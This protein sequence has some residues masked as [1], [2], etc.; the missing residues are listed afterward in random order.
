MGTPGSASECSMQS[1]T[2][3]ACPP[4]SFCVIHQ[5]T[6]Y[7]EWMRNVN[8]RFTPSEGGSIQIN[9]S[10]LVNIHQGNASSDHTNPVHPSVYTE[11]LRQVLEE[12][13]IR[14]DMTTAA[15][16]QSLYGQSQGDDGSSW[17]ITRDLAN[18]PSSAEAVSGF[19]ERGLNRQRGMV[20][21]QP[22]TFH[23]ASQSHQYS[24]HLV[25][26]RMAATS[27]MGRDAEMFTQRYRHHDLQ[28]VES[29]GFS[30]CTAQSQYYDFD[31]RMAENHFSP[32]GVL[33]RSWTQTG[34]GQ[35]TRL[36]VQQQPGQGDRQFG[37]QEQQARSDVSSG[38]CPNPKRQWHR[39]AFQQFQIPPKRSW[40]RPVET[41]AQTASANAESSSSATGGDY[42]EACYSGDL[43]TNTTSTD[44]EGQPGCGSVT[45]HSEHQP[46]VASAQTQQSED[47]D[48]IFIE[49]SEF[50][51]IPLQVTS[52]KVEKERLGVTHPCCEI[53]AGMQNIQGQQLNCVP[54]TK[55]IAPSTSAG[56][57][58]EQQRTS[59]VSGLQS[60]ADNIG[61]QQHSQ[62]QNPNLTTSAAPASATENSSSLEQSGNGNPDSVSLPA[63]TAALSGSVSSLAT[64]NPQGRHSDRT[65]YQAFTTPALHVKSE[66]KDEDEVIFVKSEPR[67]DQSMDSFSLPSVL[68]TVSLH[69][70][71]STQPE[72]ST[73]ITRKSFQK[74]S[75]E[76]FF[77][78]GNSDG[79]CCYLTQLPTQFDVH[80]R[81]VHAQERCYPC[82]HCGSLEPSSDALLHHLEQ[83]LSLQCLLLY[84]VEPSCAYNSYSAEDV[85]QHI[86]GCHSSLDTFT[87]WR[88]SVSF[89]SLK[90]FVDHVKEN[91]L[92]IVRCPHCSAKDT[93]HWR[94]LNH[95]SVSHPGSGRMI[96]VHKMFLCQERALTGWHAENKEQSATTSTQGMPECLHASNNILTDKSIN[97]PPVLPAD[98]SV[99]HNPRPKSD[100]SHIDLTVSSCPRQDQHASEDE[101][102]LDFEHEDNSEDQRC[103]Q[104]NTQ[105]ARVAVNWMTEK[106]DLSDSE[107]VASSSSADGEMSDSQSGQPCPQETTELG[108]EKVKTSCETAAPT[109]SVST[110]S[111]TSSAYQTRG[112]HV[113]KAVEA[114]YSRDQ[115]TT[116]TQ[117]Q[118][119]CGLT[120]KE[121]AD[122]AGCKIIDTND[123]RTGQDTLELGA[124][125]EEGTEID[126]VESPCEG[127]D[128]DWCFSPGN[129]SLAKNLQLQNKEL[130]SWFQKSYVKPSDNDGA[131]S[132]ALQIQCSYCSHGSCTEEHHLCHLSSHHVEYFQGFSCMCGY[133]SFHMDDSVD[134][135]CLSRQRRSAAKAQFGSLNESLLSSLSM[136]R[137]Q[138]DPQVNNDVR[139]S[140]EICS[141]QAKHFKR[142]LQDDCQAAEP[143]RKKQKLQPLKHALHKSSEVKAKRRRR[144]SSKKTRLHCK[145]CAF[146]AYSS[147]S[148]YAHMYVHHREVMQCPVCA[149]IPKN[150]RELYG[151]LSAA[152]PQMKNSLS[153]QLKVSNWITTVKTQAGSN[154]KEN[155]A[156]NMLEDNAAANRRRAHAKAKKHGD[157]AVTKRGGAAA[158]KRRVDA[159]VKKPVVKAAA[160]NFKKRRDTAAE[161][162]VKDAA[163]MKLGISAVAEIHGNA[164]V[165]KQGK[166][167]SAIKTD[168]EV[169]RYPGGASEI[170]EADATPESF[171]KIPAS[172]VIEL[173]ASSLDVETGIPS[174]CFS[175]DPSP[176]ETTTGESTEFEYRCPHCIN[177]LKT[178]EKFYAHLCYH[179]HY[180]CWKCAHCG[181]RAFG[182]STV[183]NHINKKHPDQMAS[184]EILH[185]LHISKENRCQR[186]IERCCV[187]VSEPYSEKRLQAMEK[188]KLKKQLKKEGRNSWKSKVSSKNTSR[189]KIVQ[190][191]RMRAVKPSSSTATADKWLMCPYCRSERK[192]L[193]AIE[194]EIRFHIHYK[195]FSCP[196]CT[197][198]PFE[199]SSQTHIEKHILNDHPG[200]RAKVKVTRIPEKEARFKVLLQR[201]I[202]LSKETV[203]SCKDVKRRYSLNKTAPHTVSP[204]KKPKASFS[205]NSGSTPKQ[206]LSAESSSSATSHSHQT[207]MSADSSEGS[208]SH[209]SQNLSWAQDCFN[210]T[211]AGV[212]AVHSCKLCQ[213]SFVRGN[214]TR[215]LYY[216]RMWKHWYDRHKKSAS[217]KPKRQ[218]EELVVK[219]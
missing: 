135:R 130:P 48:I 207:C 40:H 204:I 50:K 208:T 158:K 127:R 102:I 134:H 4:S 34:Q 186:V 190:K 68:E 1:C 212:E 122:I 92:Q 197:V 159:K 97:Q 184:P 75:A 145:L 136:Y 49:K 25:P 177:I 161:K 8:P 53:P 111:S 71:P 178:R 119:G 26:P 52:V 174:G 175:S 116:G 73:S 167:V 66:P 76:G 24:S 5:D 67:E 27:V 39:P 46:D 80:L 128:M 43:P 138:S 211:G 132:N 32:P 182:K 23:S 203:T 195:P 108:T 126:R 13:S 18:P 74:L 19:V 7:A 41:A 166:D 16:S 206:H 162:Q 58:V 105:D 106:L 140:Q 89:L 139:I 29:H 156:E 191:S 14:R 171:E 216:N 160:K 30:P 17:H 77:R 187:P 98:D 93:D 87:C 152:H 15:Q 64:E 101:M 6:T 199:S 82:V 189:S 84:C 94:I 124:E 180:R 169:M 141:K 154:H 69:S 28:C 104:S 155:S 21:V 142:R 33:P 54:S 107:E 86:A 163:A 83:H 170:S 209:Q 57:S 149:L 198:S 37:H 78:C 96:S 168:V 118:L 144:I 205:V 61:R 35:P 47:Y 63:T 115:P 165:K 72:M 137:T 147:S 95:I 153:S 31:P 173:Q 146:S 90:D 193:T 103:S 214:R 91:L 164:A 201:A 88:C 36:C 202:K 181:L 45:H 85:L 150:Y 117:G 99:S 3:P 110:E 210:I 113:S 38:I 114:C 200:L 157:N 131:I 79:T 143:D 219:H 213:Y 62:S 56:D 81:E 185:C 55:A 65:S 151:H 112:D 129:S 217:S 20:T 183:V 11:A 172:Q 194:R 10:M 215:K 2:Q 123:R 196:L 218:V 133:V 120:A 179:Y 125:K 12:P 192:T 109:A 44:T 42:V 100:A 59:T 121:M 60:A 22:Q 51:N 70:D 176:V 148:A 9:N 188:Q